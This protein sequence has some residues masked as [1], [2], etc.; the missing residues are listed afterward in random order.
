MPASF[1]VGDRIKVDSSSLLGL[2][3]DLSLRT[4]R[5][6]DEGDPSASQPRGGR[7]VLL[8][9]ARPARNAG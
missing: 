1:L 2:D 4:G 8:R 7:D 5:P 6:E 9:S 3:D